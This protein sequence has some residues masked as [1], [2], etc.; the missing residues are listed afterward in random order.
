MCV[1]V[2]VRA[3]CTSTDLGVMLYG[4][5]LVTWRRLGDSCSSE[6]KRQDEDRG[7]ERRKEGKRR[8][9]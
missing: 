3:Y 4:P 7:K 5:P 8:R 9:E 2:C 6:E 1:C